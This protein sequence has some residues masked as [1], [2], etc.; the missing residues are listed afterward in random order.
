VPSLLPNSHTVNE[1]YYL[2]AAY[3]VR[4]WFT[5][6]LYYAGLYLNVHERSGKQNYQH[7]VAATLRFDLTDH[8]LIKLE[9]HLMHGTYGLADMRDLNDGKELKDLITNW[10]VLLLKTTGYF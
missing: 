2:L 7:D 8:W 9:G 4:P 5:P 10:T 6:G 1:R 3:H